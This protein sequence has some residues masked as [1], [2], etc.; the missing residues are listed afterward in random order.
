MSLFS[1]ST[2]TATVSTALLAIA[3]VVILVSTGRASSADPTGIFEV[4]DSRY[5]FV[6]SACT[7]T[8]TDFVAAGSGTINGEPFWI[9][10]TSRS[11]T[12][13]VGT[14]SEVERPDKDQVWLT[15][16][17]P[18]TWTA[19]DDGIEV[20]AT[21]VDSRNEESPRHYGVLLVSCP[22]TAQE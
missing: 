8:D 11:M 9:S 1:R 5:E 13:T 10:A 17:G 20:E 22:E 19:I 12:L 2:K 21:M 3:L 4:G 18:V 6:P 16:L 15:S 14:E 7:T